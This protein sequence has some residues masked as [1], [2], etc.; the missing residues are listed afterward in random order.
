M[1]FTTIDKAC[2]FKYSYDK[3]IIDEVVKTWPE[4]L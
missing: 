1:K 3:K 2:Y 4:N